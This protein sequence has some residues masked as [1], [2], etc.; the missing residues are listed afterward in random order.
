MEFQ[1]LHGAVKGMPDVHIRLLARQMH[2]ARILPTAPAIRPARLRCSLPAC[3]RR[4]LPTAALL[5]SRPTA[6]YV[7]T[8]MRTR[9]LACGRTPS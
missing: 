7:T 9:L 1:L 5:F 2:N 4:S 6:P 8:V 3:L